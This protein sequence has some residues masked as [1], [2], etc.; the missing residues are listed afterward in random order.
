[1][2]PAYLGWFGIIRLG[3][4]QT[5]LG[6]IVVLTTSTLNRVMVVEYAL[7]AILPGA[8]VAL[9]YAVQLSRPA[10][11]HGSD[12]GGRRTPWII[13]GMACL[14]AGGVLAAL[15][16]AWMESET[17]WGILLAVVAF[18]MIGAGVGAS[19]TTLL[20]L[21]A[22]R[23]D[24]K[25]RAA[26]AT[27]VW[28]MMIVGFVITAGTAGHFLDPYSST[29]LV[30]VTSTVS[31][32]AFLLTLLAVIG[33]EPHGIENVP[34]VQPANPSAETMASF[35]EALSEVWADA[36]ARRFTIFV[37]ASMLAYN[38][39][40]LILEPFAGSVFGMTPG[41]STQLA[42]MQHGGVLAGMILVAIAASAIGGRILGSLKMWTVGGCIASGIALIVLA[43]GGLYAPAFPI[44]A[45]VFAL[46]FANGAF[47]VAAIAS[48]M[49]LAGKGK[50]KR[51]G[52]RMGLWGAAQAIAFGLGG[53]LGT[54]AID[55]TRM[56]FD[57]TAVAYGTVFLG[58]ALVFLV[59]ARLA[60]GIAQPNASDNQVR[61]TTP[62]EGYLAGLG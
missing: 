55:I 42:G 60:M 29:R 37:F 15:A 20:A 28:V 41:Q 25:R 43:I 57:S 38:T 24:P 52:I 62:G 14:A 26:A 30:V 32:L 56:I 11:G 12:V 46:G 7:P 39:Q 17:L 22:K 9:H 21:L 19:G 27:I 53:F 47:A 54:V 50:T 2:T 34:S 6:A 48:M 13:G 5:A 3:L 44:K 40:D 45:S 36:E 1:M 61:A 16:T 51:E 4:V 31:V 49:S 8:L 35:K 10:M 23:V 18:I 59:A 58:E 33:I